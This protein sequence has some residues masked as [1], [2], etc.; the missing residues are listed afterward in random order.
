MDKNYLLSELQFIADKVNELKDDVNKTSWDINSESIANKIGDA[1]CKG[2]SGLSYFVNGIPMM[3]Y[4]LNNYKESGDIED[5]NS[6]MKIANGYMDAVV[7]VR[8]SFNMLD[9]LAVAL[10]RN[11]NNERHA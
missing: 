1:L 11:V 8:E 2:R 3:E 9:E 7:K 10:K 4:R 6:F 5:L